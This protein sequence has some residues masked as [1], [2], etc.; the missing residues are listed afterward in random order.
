MKI[1][2]TISAIL[3]MTAVFTY[4]QDDPTKNIEGTWLFV[5]AKADDNDFSSEY[6]FGFLDDKPRKMTLEEGGALIYEEAVVTGMG[7]TDATRRDF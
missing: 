7:I 1:R 4:S 6:V 5:S 3:I 2:Y